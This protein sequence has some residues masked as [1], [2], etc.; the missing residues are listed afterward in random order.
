MADRP[1]I[2]RA[3]SRDI[4]SRYVR[5]IYRRATADLS[6]GIRFISATQILAIQTRIGQSARCTATPTQFFLSLSLSPLRYFFFFFSPRFHPSLVFAFKRTHDWP[7]H[8][9]DISSQIENSRFSIGR[10]LRVYFSFSILQFLWIRVVEFEF[11][12]TSAFE[13]IFLS[14]RNCK[15]YWEQH[16]ILNFE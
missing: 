12:V 10:V 13:R 14:D 8:C 7:R 3:R 9:S 6:A 1:V 5:R 11:V 16:V 4:S 2:N 15:R